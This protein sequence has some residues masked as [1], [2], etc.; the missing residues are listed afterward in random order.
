M[1]CIYI[2]IYTSVHERKDGKGKDGKAEGRHGKRGKDEENL[3]LPTPRQPVHRPST[4]PP[5]H[6]QCP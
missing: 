2:Y 4:A 5:L 3:P 6:H 1:M